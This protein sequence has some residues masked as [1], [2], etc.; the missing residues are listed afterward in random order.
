MSFARVA[1]SRRFF[2][3]ELLFHMLNILTVLPSLA[4]RETD[5]VSCLQVG[6]P[7]LAHTLFL[8]R[9]PCFGLSSSFIFDDLHWWSKKS[10]SYET[11]PQEVIDCHVSWT[12]DICASPY[13]GT[14]RQPL[15]RRPKD[16]PYSLLCA[17][18]LAC[19]TVCFSSRCR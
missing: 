18:W 8:Y 13:R 15:Y 2:F 6:G 10:E 3:L 4:G 1:N 5:L 16:H 19:L 17:T 11:Y 14:N 9:W 12:Q 7:H